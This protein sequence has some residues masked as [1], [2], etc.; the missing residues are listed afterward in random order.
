M[1]VKGLK[2]IVFIGCRKPANE[3]R[4]VRRGYP[5]LH[6]SHGAGQC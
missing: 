5:M 4:K 1:R 2:K 6:Q 3:E